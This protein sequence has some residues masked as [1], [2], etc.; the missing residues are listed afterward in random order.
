[1]IDQKTNENIAR[2]NVL[3]EIED[4]IELLRRFVYDERR[5]RNG[6]RDRNEATQITGRIDDMI[7]T[8]RKAR[9]EVPD[10]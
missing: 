9:G 6:W 7:H 1:M 5:D 2:E 4:Q 10:Y 8:L 3:Q